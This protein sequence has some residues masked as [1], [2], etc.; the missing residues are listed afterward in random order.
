[1]NINLLSIDKIENF[2]G[3]FLVYGYYDDNYFALYIRDNDFSLLY[4]DTNC[5]DEELKA[6]FNYLVS[7]VITK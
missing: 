6:I 4:D 1:M 7:N 2:E 3:S 5:T